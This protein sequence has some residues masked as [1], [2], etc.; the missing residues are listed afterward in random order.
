MGL[1]AVAPLLPTL[2]EGVLI[3]YVRLKRP[4]YNGESALRCLYRGSQ[5]LF[6]QGL[7]EGL[8]WAPRRDGDDTVVVG[9]RYEWHTFSLFHPRYF[10]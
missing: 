1:E 3:N 8:A 6:D 5:R 7:V 2:G 10:G 4:D 9:L